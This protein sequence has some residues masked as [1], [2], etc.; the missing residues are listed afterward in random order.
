MLVEERAPKGNI[1]DSGYLRLAGC[2]VI[3]DLFRKVQS[4]VIGNGNE[5]EKL[6]FKYSNHP[7][8]IRDQKF[9]GFNLS[10]EQ[11]FV[12]QM[13]IE[14]PDSKNIALD[15]FLSTPDSIH[16]FE[17]KD[18]MAFDTKKSAGEVASLNDS[19]SF[20][21]ERDPLNRPVQKHIVLWNCEDLSDASFKSKEGKSMLMTGDDFAKLVGIDKKVIDEHRHCDADINKAYIISEMRKIVAASDADIAEAA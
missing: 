1:K 20:I 14:N 11:A 12:V 5:L 4:T 16:I 15:C 17:I 8:T 18:G 3:A 10:Q 9:P 7:N 19:G 2:P 6:I 13:K 21:K